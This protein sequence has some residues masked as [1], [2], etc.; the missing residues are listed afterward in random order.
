MGHL[1][2]EGIAVAG[3][4][5]L[6]VDRFNGLFILERPP[7][8]KSIAPNNGSL[9]VSWETFGQP[10]RLQRSTSLSHPNRQELVGSESMTETT[11]PQSSGSEFFRLVKLWRS[12]MSR[13][14][15]PAT[16]P[17]QLSPING[18]GFVRVKVPERS[19][20]SRGSEEC[21]CPIP[22]RQSRLGRRSLQNLPRVH[23]IPGERTSQ[24]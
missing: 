16:S 23:A 15:L 22:I 7:F 11:I 18:K 24:P 12:V 19:E 10:V 6:A 4:K 13:A 8:L 1:W 9:E 3:N 14:D 21:E 17:F 20:R 5:V 2:G